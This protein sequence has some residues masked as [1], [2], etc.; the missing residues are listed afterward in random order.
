M[1]SFHLQACHR[2]MK[3]HIEHLVHHGS[4]VIDEQQRAKVI[5]Q[6]FDEIIGNHECCSHGLDFAALGLPVVDLSGLDL[7]SRTSAQSR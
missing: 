2:H 1:R 4:V 5:F 6:H 7:C 3:N